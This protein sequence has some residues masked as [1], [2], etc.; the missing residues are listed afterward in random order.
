MGGLVS[1]WVVL[2][3]HTVAGDDRDADGVLRDEVVVRWIGEAC[4]AYLECCSVLRDTSERAG[5]SVRCD[6]G[7]LPR[8][9]M[10][11]AVH[12]VNVSAGATEVWPTAFRIA[13]RIR[14]FG[15]DG[16]VAFNAAATVTVVDPATGKP[17]EIGDDVRDELIALA[18]AARHFN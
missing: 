3:G 1:K 2:L 15:G 11:G 14:A 13:F 12:T 9:A 17:G 8:G 7:D 6:M 4:D 18:H 10:F 16:D 5:R